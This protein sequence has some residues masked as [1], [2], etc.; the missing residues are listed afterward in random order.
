[1]TARNP[2][3]ANP[4][5][6]YG[7]PIVKTC[8][9]LKTVSRAKK[10][11]ID[12]LSAYAKEETRYG[13]VVALAG[14]HGSGKTHLLMLLAETVRNFTTFEVGCLYVKPDDT[15]LFN[16][17][18][19]AVDGI[20]RIG[21]IH[22]LDGARRALAKHE[23]EQTR[24]TESISTRIDESID[25]NA[26]IEEGT[27]DTDAL[28]NA[29]EEA[30]H[31]TGV[32][33]DFI[34][35]L[36]LCETSSGDKAFQWLLGNDA[37]DLEV[38]GLSRPLR[39]METS[40]SSG[41]SA[42][43]SVAI[44]GLSLLALLHRVA[45]SPFVVLIDQ[46]DVLIPREVDGK[47]RFPALTTLM[48]AF[49]EQ[50]ALVFLAGSEAAWRR[51]P[52]DVPPRLRF[53]TPF[54]VGAL[55]RGEIAMLVDA[56]MDKRGQ[57]SKETLAALDEL[58]GGNPREV[59]AIC[60]QLFETLGGRLSRATKED[61]AASGRRSGTVDGRAQLALAMT[62]EVITD[63]GR[64]SRDVALPDGRV[65]DRLLR[66]RDRVVAVFLVVKAS[67][68]LDET[69][70][71]RNL[72]DAIQTVRETMAGAPVVAVT[73]G[74]TS[75]EVRE[76]FTSSATVIPFDDRK[77]KAQ[78]EAEMVRIDSTAEPKKER[79]S[80]ATETLER[81]ADRLDALEG[82]RREEA[83]KAQERFAKAAEKAMQ[84]E[85]KEREL[86]TRWQLLSE[87]DVVVSESA[88][89]NGES[90]RESIRSILINNEAY[91][92]DRLL[93]ELGG[94]Y[95]DVLNI[96]TSA[97][98]TSVSM[99]DYIRATKAGILADMRARLRRH[100]FFAD[101]ISRPV[102]TSIFAG[103]FA[104]FVMLCWAIWKV[105][106][107]FSRYDLQ[108][109]T[110]RYGSMTGYMFSRVLWSLPYA[111]AVGLVCS[112]L[113]GLLLYLKDPSRLWRRRLARLRR[114]ALRTRDG[115]HSVQNDPAVVS[116]RI[117]S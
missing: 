82:Q 34:Q 20:G 58:T 55:E 37:S 85:T 63:Y 5:A 78:L 76:L 73:V 65:V 72:G 8:D 36:K 83:G 99:G 68:N 56:L 17:Y 90:E 111:L 91:R 10:E 108:F 9:K 48:E 47:V 26:L 93:D 6:T 11:L 75:A 103:V 41:I 46:F 64:I 98:D 97:L 25:L 28:E 16:V 106:I 94:L 88:L 100:T 30:L 70:Q 7:V 27:I 69:V 61:V 110:E 115:I 15:S 49:K 89:N 51:L 77:Y 14:A 92:N 59:L 105:N 39:Q 96:A 50:H 102:R 43:E 57:L 23:V 109:L 35:A 80:E 29:L 117:P 60:Y 107:G 53:R 1:V 95:L 84:P 114:A 22:R 4:V 45:G 18:R 54:A 33:S 32:P 81:I 12:Y 2:F 67:D 74:Y 101:L 24:I 113:I 116:A 31:A 66:Q 21:L 40:S 44:D 104:A 87:L 52:P 19:K 13:G 86:K 62:D 71:A 42:E 38:L 79:G 112:C 3:P